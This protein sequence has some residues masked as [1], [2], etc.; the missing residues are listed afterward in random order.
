MNAI[1]EFSPSRAELDAFAAELDALLRE[2][3]ESLG[4]AD[5]VHLAR[6]ERMGR[7]A[8]A[9]GYATAWIAPNPV[10]MALLSTGR[11]TRWA[12]VGHHVSHR[13]YDRVPNVPEERRSRSFAVGKR[14]FVDWLDWIDPEAWAHEHNKLHHYRL[15]ETADPD[16]VEQNLDWLRDSNLPMPL[17]YAIVAFFASTWKFSYYA[18]NTLRVLLQAEREK[19]GPHGDADAEPISLASM[20]TRSELWTR[21]FLPYAGVQFGL[22]PL[23]FAPLGP[24]AVGNVLANSLGAELLTNL[25][26]FVVITTNHAGEDVYSFETPVRA[27]RGEFYARQ[28]AGSVNFRTGTELVD[29]LHGY[30]NYQIE[31]HLFPD[32]PMLAYRRIQPKVKAICEAHGVP[33]LQ[34]SIGTR[35]RKTLDVM[36]GK[37]GMRRSRHTPA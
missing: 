19:A 7:L 1:H 23:L 31:H 36:V 35:L 10:S 12:M 30:L 21:C 13:G 22:V 16:L 29:F 4:D 33:Y 15:G 18:P 20:F 6:V 26:A 8:T 17:R 11:F 32:L 25:H 24:A 5:L 14:R 9:L 2:T 28:A 3:R 27:G 34:E 37:T